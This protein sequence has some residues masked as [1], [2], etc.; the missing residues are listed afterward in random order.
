[1]NQLIS[2]KQRKLS[3]E[4]MGIQNERKNAV[5]LQRR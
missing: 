2:A 1:M 3:S 4:R 5:I